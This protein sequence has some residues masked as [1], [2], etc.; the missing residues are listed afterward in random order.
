MK[1][2]QIEE[3]KRKRIDF[4]GMGATITLDNRKS[5]EGFTFFSDGKITFKGTNYPYD[6]I[7]NVI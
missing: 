6:E 5:E 7:K 2:E 3:F 1:E 4:A